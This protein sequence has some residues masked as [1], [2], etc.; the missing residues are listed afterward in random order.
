MS[1]PHERSLDRAGA[2]AGVVAVVLLVALVM[3][4]PALPGPD[5][6]IGEIAMDAASSGTTLLLGSYLGMLMAAAL[7][8][9]GAACTGALRRREGADDGWWLVALAGIAAS[10]MSMAGNALSASWVRSVEHGVR[11]DALWFGYSIDHSF[12]TLVAVPL[13]VFLLGIGMAGRRGAL[14]RRLAPAA[15]VVAAL[16]VVGAGSI[17]GDELEGGPLA[18]PLLLGYLGLLLWI[19]WASVVLWRGARAEPARLD[20]VPASP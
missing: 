20:P 19:I 18:I 6:A 5:E 12:G 4:V 7:L 2:L 8:V 9:F 16:L 13:A 3:V 17:T 10:S 1:A 15:L 11:G 14:P